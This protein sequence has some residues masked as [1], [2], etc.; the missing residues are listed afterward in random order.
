MSTLAGGGPA[1]NAAGYLDATGT[2]ATFYGPA[3]I[4]LDTSYASATFLL[5]STSYYGVQGAFIA[6][7]DG[8]LIR[9][10]TFPDGVVTTIAGGFPSNQCGSLDPDPGAG[11]FHATYGSLNSPS[12][13]ALGVD[14]NYPQNMLLYVAD[15]ANHA[16]RILT[17]PPGYSSGTPG[18][19]AI[20]MAGCP[21]GGVNPSC[22]RHNNNAVDG[23]LTSATFDAPTG[24]AL[25]PNGTLYISDT[26]NSLIRQM[27]TGNMVVTTVAGI[28]GAPHASNPG[29]A[30]GR[31]QAKYV[32][33]L[34]PGRISFVRNGATSCPAGNCYFLFADSGHHKV[35]RIQQYEL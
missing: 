26:G 18:G 9:Y 20:L 29:D 21:V 2:T 15:T 19:V 22:P 8:C 33:L 13:L 30:S 7:R 31:T 1:G 11:F 35:A 14:P 5:G 16:I 10:V 34:N 23:P 32:T 17:L 4:A 6:D 12:G 27:N 28:F 24:L 25:S 3:A